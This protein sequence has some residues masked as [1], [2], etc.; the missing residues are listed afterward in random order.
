M[1]A[2]GREHR[3]SVADVGKL[4]DMGGKIIIG[5]GAE[6]ACAGRQGMYRMIGRYG[7]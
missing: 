1:L 4:F 5:V 6:C 3:D 2:H 7:I